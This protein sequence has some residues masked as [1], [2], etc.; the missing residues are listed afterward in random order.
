M[1]HNDSFEQNPGQPAEE[2]TPVKGTGLAGQGS[3][4]RGFSPDSI[5]DR[6][7][8][9]SQPESAG[10][11]R[12]GFQPNQL[13][14]EGRFSENSPKNPSF[15]A[16]S[17][18]SEPS[19]SAVPEELPQDFAQPVLLPPIPSP[20]NPFQPIPAEPDPGLLFQ[21]W[22]QPEIIPPTRIPHLGHLCLLAI[23]ALFGLLGTSLLTWSAL[24]FHLFGIS[25]IQKAITNIHYALGSQVALYLLTFGAC[26]LIFPLVWRKG[27]FAGLQWNAAAALHLRWRLFGAACLCFGL[28]MIDQLVLPGP[29][30]APIDKLFQTR[31]AA[32]LLFAFGVTFAP[33]FEEIIFRGFLLPA[34]ATACDWTVER[35]THNRPRPLDENGNPQWSISAMVVASVLTSVP[36]ALMHAEQTARALGPFLLL[37]TVSL[38]LCWVRLSA[39]S[40]AA[41]VLV[42]ASY[43]L[44]LFSLMLLGTGGFRHLDKL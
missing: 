25:T 44:L 24:H 19:S 2:P 13:S 34:L 9:M 26:L 39:R 43:N 14:P 20:P 41:S 4:G 32:W 15:P 18:A 16:A 5:P 31:N 7:P 23:L 22:S 21:S 28:A 27:F 6:I 36:F 38:V 1:S 8:D 37:V 42:H 40:L 33:F 29:S 35:H 11:G 17:S 12:E 10:T 30:N 3:A